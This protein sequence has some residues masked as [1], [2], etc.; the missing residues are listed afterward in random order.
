MLY[1]AKFREDVLREFGK[2]V[3]AAA[4]VIKTQIE[5]KL[6][7]VVERFT[8]R[9][10]EQ[11]QAA[12]DIRERNRAMVQQSRS[13]L[14]MQQL[15]KKARRLLEE[16]KLELDALEKLLRDSELSD[17]GEAGATSSAELR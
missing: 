13:N 4:E 3:N 8:K 17:G 5:S 12:T 7:S 6:N 10:S 2:S 14:D 11:K 15:V 1:H 16:L 9:V